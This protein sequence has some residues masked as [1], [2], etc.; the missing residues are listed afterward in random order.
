MRT[1][2]LLGLCFAW[3]SSQAQTVLPNV[4]LDSMIF[5]VRQGR[6]CTEVMKA[7][8]DELKKQGA[9]LLET[10]DALRFSLNESKTLTSLLNNQKEERRLDGEENKIREKSLKEKIKRRN[11]LI[12]GEGLIILCLILLL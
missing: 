2:L 11:K 8:A 6:K 1:A 12:V 7:Q 5:E 9:E 3:L 4:I 10:S